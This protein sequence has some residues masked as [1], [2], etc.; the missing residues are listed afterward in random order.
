MHDHLVRA[1]HSS[2]RSFESVHGV[3]ESALEP[4]LGRPLL[5][6]VLAIINP[7]AGRCDADEVVARLDETLGRRPGR[8]L[9]FYRTTGEEALVPTITALIRR[10]DPDLIIAAGGDGTVGAV[11]DAIASLPGNHEQRPILGILPLGTVNLLARELAVP[12]DLSEGV[13]L[14]DQPARTRAIDLIRIAEQHFACR[15]AYGSYAEV[16][17]GTTAATKRAVRRLAY[18][19]QALSAFARPRSRVFEL[20]IDGRIEWLR[21][22]SLVLTNVGATGSGDLRFGP[23][24]QPD[25]GEIEVCAIHAEAIHEWVSTMWHGLRGQIKAAPPISMLKAKGPLRIRVQGPIVVRGDG[26]PVIDPF[27]PIEVLPGAIEI[28]VPEASSSEPSP[29]PKPDQKVA[30]SPSEGST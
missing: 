21:A 5:A 1:S 15:V 4:E 29:E 9:T 30:R 16:S 7:V 24:I 8:R 6:R 22:S 18:V 10:H 26:E 28:V 25:D 2:P 20:E 13:A 19:W 11:I 23:T 14:L 27:A 17:A 3:R 12:S